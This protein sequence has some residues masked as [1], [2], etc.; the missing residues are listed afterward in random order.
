[1]GGC[2]SGSCGSGCHPKIVCPCPEAGNPEID[3]LEKVVNCYWQNHQS[4]AAEA[5]YYESLE[6][7]QTA[8]AEAADALDDENL[9]YDTPDAIPA[10]SLTAA[11]QALAAAESELAACA[12]FDALYQAIDSKL[13][14]LSGLTPAL[15]YLTAWRIG[16]QAG[17]APTV[18]YL[19]AGAREGA[20]ALVELEGDESRVDRDRLPPILR[21][22]DLPVEDVQLCLAI[23][24]R[25]LQW[26]GSKS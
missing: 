2:S 5:D 10:T 1:M 6:D 25:Q 7:L 24:K 14:Q 8:I 13:G 4:L 21:H 12:D 11:R 22:P 19:D 3:S 26:L 17:F 18:I 16:L 9:G 23:C 15:V 20:A